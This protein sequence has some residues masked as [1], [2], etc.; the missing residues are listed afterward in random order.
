MFAVLHFA[1]RSWMP[2]GAVWL[3]PTFAFRYSQLRTGWGVPRERWKGCRQGWHRQ[4]NHHVVR[5]D[6]LSL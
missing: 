5:I 2:Y 1:S 6:R 3:P 4:Q